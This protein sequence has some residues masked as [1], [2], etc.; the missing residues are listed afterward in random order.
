M[1]SLK[2]FLFLFLVSFLIGQCTLDKSTIAG[3]ESQTSSDTSIVVRKPNIYIYP[4]EKI[5]LKIEVSFPFG[6]KIIISEPACTIS[7]WDITVDR[8][9]LINNAYQYLFYECEI[10]NHFQTHEGWKVPQKD[11]DNFF[12]ES[13]NKFGL[14]EMEIYDFVEYWV[15]KLTDFEYYLIFPQKKELINQLIDL[16]FSKEPQNLQRIFYLFK[17]IDKNHDVK[18]NPPQYNSVDRK[19]YTIIEWGG[20][21]SN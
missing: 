10:P 14:N 1:N 21:V 19:G 5:D 20:M 7:G 6:G 18:I 4:E 16:N 9:G 8:S 12:N 13:L 17:G 15:P 11:L 3:F 2:T